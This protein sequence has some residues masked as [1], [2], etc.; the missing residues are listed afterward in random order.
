MLAMRILIAAAL[1]GTA[2]SASAVDGVSL[3]YGRGNGVDVFGVEARSAEWRRWPARDGRRLAAY[4]MGSVGYWHAR[5]PSEHAELWDFGVAPVLRLQAPDQSSGTSYLEGSLG[6]HFL[7]GNRINGHREFSTRFQ[8]GEF[9]GVGML[10]GARRELG[11]GVRL[12]HV[13][14]GGLRNPNPGLTFLS[15]VGRYE[16]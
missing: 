16:L 7:S 3:L 8:F 11:L 2:L 1:L 12:Q 13:S 9:V 14:N 5:E 4:G 6:V 10:F 15:I